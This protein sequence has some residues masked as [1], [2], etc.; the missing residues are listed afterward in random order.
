MLR[1]CGQWLA[2]FCGLIVLIGIQPHAAAQQLH[3]ADVNSWTR[4]GIGSW[5]QVRAYAVSLDEAG[6]VQQTNLRD[7]KS[8]LV[9]VADNYYTLKVET[10]VEVAGRKFVAEPNYLKQGYN[11]ESNGQTVDVKVL[12]PGEVSIDGRKYPSEIQQVVVNGDE[13]KRVSLIHVS[14]LV[15]PYVL[16]RE[17]KATD[18]A[19]ITKSFDSLVEVVAIDMPWR[20]L[21]ESKTVSFV[22]TTHRQVSGTTTVVMET[23]CADVPGGVVAHSS[24]EISP[25]GRIL[26]RETLELME[27]Q[28]VP[29]AT[30]ATTTSTTTSGRRRLFQRNNRNRS[31]G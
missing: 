6:K 29:I 17:T 30:E 28:V 26:G 25:A 23:H 9:E 5:K 15:P 27:Y 8:T 18:A 16:R 10:T 14:E 4:F 3:A 22:K 20:V 24:K 2:S 21:S 19:G 11:G 12:G 1:L 13:L 7:T 31:N